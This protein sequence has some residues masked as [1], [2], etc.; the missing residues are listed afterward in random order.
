[1]KSKIKK[2]RAA[3]K[4]FRKAIRIL[5]VPIYLLAIAIGCFGEGHLGFSI[6]LLLVSIGRLAVNIMTDEYVYKK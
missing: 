2:V 1:M 5:E 4:K 3:K 6:F